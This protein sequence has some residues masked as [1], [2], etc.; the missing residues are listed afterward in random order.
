LS[1]KRVVL[2]EE[3]SILDFIFETNNDKFIVLVDF[4]KNIR[5]HPGGN[6]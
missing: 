3:L 5:R 6:L 1:A 4:R 2:S